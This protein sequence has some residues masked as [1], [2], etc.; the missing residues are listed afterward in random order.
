MV[1]TTEVNGVLV[2]KAIVGSERLLSVYRRMVMEDVVV[3]LS[4]SVSVS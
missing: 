2:T 4:V 1:A 3:T